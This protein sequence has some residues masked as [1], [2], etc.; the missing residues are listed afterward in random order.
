MSDPERLADL[1][2]MCRELGGLID[3]I[4]ERGGLAGTGFALLLF[5]FGEE[6]RP[7]WMTYLSNAEREDMLR[8][9]REFLERHEAGT[10]SDVGT[11]GRRPS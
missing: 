9:M 7:G 2:E 11:G 3:T 10:V 4:L 5:D 8:E 6:G 1:E